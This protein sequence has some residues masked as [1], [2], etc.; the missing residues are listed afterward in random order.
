[1][2][3]DQINQATCARCG[4]KMK[5]VRSI[6]RLGVTLPPVRL[7]QCTGCD[8]TVLLESRGDADRH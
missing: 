1:M 6:H 2:G 7:L 5:V 8:H 3:E 4:A